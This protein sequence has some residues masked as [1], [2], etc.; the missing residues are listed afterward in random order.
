M[1]LWLGNYLSPQNRSL[2]V[3]LLTKKNRDF[4]LRRENNNKDIVIDGK[5]SFSGLDFENVYEKKIENKRK[6]REETCEEG[7]ER[8]EE[9]E[10]TKVE[11]PCNTGREA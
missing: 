5:G 7:P 10:N 11:V 8:G 2:I 6:N 1:K 9:K 4:K 3:E